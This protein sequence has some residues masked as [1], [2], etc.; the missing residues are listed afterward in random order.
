ML[1]HRPNLP[2]RQQRQR[3]DWVF[4]FESSGDRNPLLARVQIDVIRGLLENAEHDDTFSI[5]TASTQLHRLTEQQTATQANIDAA[6]AKL[7]QTHL[8]GALDLAGALRGA[9]D[10]APG[11]D[12]VVADY[13]QIEARVLFWMAGEERALRI[14]Q[15]GHSIYKDTSGAIMEVRGTPITDPQSIDKNDPAQ[16]A[17]YQLGKQ[18]ILGLGFQMGGPKF[19]VTCD[20]YGIEIDEDFG[21]A[22]VKPYRSTYPAVPKLWYAMEA[23]AIEATKRGPRAADP[24]KCKNTA[25]AVRGRFLHCKLPGGRLLS[26]CDPHVVDAETPWGQPCEKLRFM[27]VDT[28]THKWSRQATYGG[29]LV[30]NVVQAASRDLM[31]EAM[32]R[33]PGTPYVPILTVHDEIVA[34]VLEG[35]GSVKEFEDLMA[36]LPAWA[37]GCPVAAEGWK[38]QRYHK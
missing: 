34:E 5:V 13:A 14:M 15:A 32:L 29:K 18:S 23:A 2:T 6:M 27:G 3:R 9:I 10:A 8:V 25:W 20:G 12:L 21:K 26:Y 16:Q 33:C 37:E 4:L 19:V 22:V 28:Y 7:E 38:S 24:V 17:L 35:Q 30:E 36:K 1:R 11:T 31:A